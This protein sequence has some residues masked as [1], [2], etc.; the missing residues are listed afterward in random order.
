VKCSKIKVQ[1][2]V[3]HLDDRW[4]TNAH[5]ASRIFKL[6]IQYLDTKN[7]TNHTL[8]NECSLCANI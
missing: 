5:V 7:N 3:A 6:I 8:Y 1:H 4:L 2:A